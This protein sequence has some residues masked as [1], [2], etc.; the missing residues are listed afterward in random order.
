MG[1][2]AIN[3]LLILAF[4]DGS[5]LLFLRPLQVVKCPA[6]GSEPI[7]SRIESQRVPL[8]DRKM[9]AK[10]RPCRACAAGSLLLADSKVGK[11]LGLALETWIRPIMW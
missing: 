2:H 10:M 11:P 7:L 5:M 3:E 6:A 8:P 1:S 4:L 9:H